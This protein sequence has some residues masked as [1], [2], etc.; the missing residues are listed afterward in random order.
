M[1][2]PEEI[3]T[4]FKEDEQKERRWKL[5]GLIAL[6]I[7]LVAVC[8]FVGYR[9]FLPMAES[10]FIQEAT[11]TPTVSQPVEDGETP[12]PPT[13]APTD[14]PEPT[15]RASA[16]TKTGTLDFLILGV[17]APY[18]DEPKG[19]DAIRLVHID[20]STS[21][22]T[23]LAMPRDLWVTTPVLES[24]DINSERLGLTY[25]HAKENPPDEKDEVVYGTNAL[26]QSL[27][28][29]FGF[30]PDHYI[31]V[32][33]SNF[34]VI[35]EAIDGLTLSVPQ[36]FKS[37]NYVFSPGMQNLNGDQALEYASNML[38]DTE[39]DRFN[40][41]DLVLEAIMDKLTSPQ[42]IVSIPE[43]ISEFDDTITTDL[44][45]FEITELACLF[46][47]VSM[48]AVNYVEIDQTL[49]TKDTDSDILF[50]DYGGIIDLLK[51][52]FD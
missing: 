5:V 41:Q 23:V 12:P 30:I 47:D 31:T 52:I 25:Y 22:V 33:I 15:K 16:C 39:W 17:D 40:R 2:A 4:D 29:N 46:D 9:Y 1:E 3:K 37:V 38:I 24:L 45:L 44:S 10:L 27:Y 6:I 49:V 36:E 35:I 8:S 51:E 18:T 11:A 32:H 20:F 42:I 28:D 34:P 21:E 7:F 43:L 50:P 48:D 14:V 19:A 13:L 26:A